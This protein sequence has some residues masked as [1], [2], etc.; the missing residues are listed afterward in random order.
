MAPVLLLLAVCWSAP[1]VG[2][3]SYLAMSVVCKL[4]NSFFDVRCDVLKGK[5]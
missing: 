4:V 1:T 2:I 5:S 3:C